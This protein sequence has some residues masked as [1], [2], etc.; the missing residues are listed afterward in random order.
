MTNYYQRKFMNQ[1]KICKFISECRINKNLPQ[2]QLAKKL[3]I[4]A[5]A[6]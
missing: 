1:D 3:N 2:E 6:I 4:Y 5:R